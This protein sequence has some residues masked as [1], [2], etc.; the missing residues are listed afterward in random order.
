[1]NVK[2]GHGLNRH[3]LAMVLWYLALDNRIF[4]FASLCLRSSIATCENRSTLRRWADLAVVAVIQM[5]LERCRQLAL[6]LMNKCT[7]YAITLRPEIGSLY[8]KPCGPSI[9]P[10]ARWPQGHQCH[11]WI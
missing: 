11:S 2:G 7:R 4:E 1:V 10:L 9:F 8:R 6:S 5:F 3:K